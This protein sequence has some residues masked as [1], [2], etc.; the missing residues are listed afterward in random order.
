MLNSIQKFDCKLLNLIIKKDKNAI[1]YLYLDP[2]LI[3]TGMMVAQIQWNH[4]GSVLAVA[5]SQRALGQEKEVNV[6]QF[7]NPFGEV[8]SSALYL[9]VCDIHF[10][11]NNPVH[12]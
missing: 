9:N 11:I 10:L 7:Y 8:R 6:V 5:G 12:D 4:S 2:V 1:A 3:D